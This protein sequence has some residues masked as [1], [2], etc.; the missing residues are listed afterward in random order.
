MK[1]LM[2][3]TFPHGGATIAARRQK[4]AL[5]L[6][7]MECSLVSI[8]ENVASATTRVIRE[9]NE[10]ILDVPASAWSYSGRIT[11]AYC[12][13]NRSAISNTWFSFWP[14]ETFLD[15]ELLRICLDFDVIHFHWIAQMVSSRLL[16]KLR[17]HKRRIVITGHDMN[18]FT[19]G[20]HYSA[21][22]LN[23]KDSCEKCPQLLVDPLDLV[24]ISFITKIK[25]F[26]ELSATWIF[27]SVWLADLFRN[28]RLNDK[29]NKESCKVL[30]NCIDTD[31]FIYLSES[32]RQIQRKLL[33]FREDEFIYVAGAADN[34]ELRK[35]FDYI[36]SGIN[37]LADV[38]NNSQEQQNRCAVVT[39][40][41]VKP[42]LQIHTPYIRHL[43]LGEV[44][45][46]KVT[47]L[48]QAVDL[49]L[50]PSV[51]EN[52]S[53]LILE[54]LMCG[55]PVLAFRVGGV[56]D[57]V[58]DKINGWIVD[59]IS[60]Q[61]FGKKLASTIHAKSL[62]EMRESTEKW[63]DQNHQKYS[64][65]QIANQLMAIYEN[66]ADVTRIMRKTFF[67]PEPESSREHYSALF[68]R[69]VANDTNSHSMLA[70]S[71]RRHIKSSIGDKFK[72]KTDRY[73]TIPAI[74]A[75]YT[76][77]VHYEPLG[78]VSW[79]LKNGYV[80]FN[81]P[82][83]SKPA[84]MLGIPN[85]DWVPPLVDSALNKLITSVNGIAADVTNVKSQNNGGSFY[86]WIALKPEAIRFGTYNTLSLTFSESSVPESKDPRGMSVL[87]TS[88]TLFDLSFLSSD[89]E[90]N[91][92]PSYTTLSALALLAEQQHYLWEEWGDEINAMASLRNDMET[93]IDMLSTQETDGGEQAR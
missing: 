8:R 84:L 7:G 89:I 35:G 78:R 74:Y 75:G 48:L 59:Q 52:F 50:F 73:H 28:S 77:M 85:H 67:L 82:L 40:G 88:V 92:T 70:A 81:P 64:Y 55:C 29:K 86:I 21:G 87:C 61:H 12:I 13:N 79:L 51:E 24:K 17:L 56:P 32:D 15:D 83:G 10:I 60:H 80:I 31:K 16:S 14:C 69:V 44:N 39:F 22:C 76:D 20:C 42:N 9:G 25:A 58:V 49:L 33:G 47:E 57:I 37:H 23:F 62:K 4:D 45:E 3:C 63:R 19:G 65:N 46:S 36:E 72:S 30:Y 43:H 91:T 41:R 68:S 38:L 93:W 66:T 2:V 1:I 6:A 11:S 27:P 34:S 71:I 5:R 54:S 26:F 90:P 18:H 53:N